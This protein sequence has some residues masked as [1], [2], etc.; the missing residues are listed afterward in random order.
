MEEKD[1]SEL[2]TTQEANTKESDILHILS[3]S[4]PF[5]K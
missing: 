4:I 3:V 1:R 2:G 5:P